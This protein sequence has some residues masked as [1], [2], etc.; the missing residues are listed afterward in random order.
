MPIDIRPPAEDELRASMIAAETA[1][2]VGAIEDVDWERERKALPVSR[3]LAAFDRGKPVALAGAYKFDLTVPGGELPCAGVTWVGVMPTHRRQ[4]ILRDFMKRQLADVQGWGEPIA[5]LWASEAAIYGRFGYGHAIPNAHMK[6][7]SA[8]FAL[9]DAAAGSIRL[10]DAE[11]AF[12]LVRPVYERVRA[13]RTGMLSRDE[14]W[15]KEH[16]LAEHESWRHGASRKFY[17]VVEI[18]GEVEGYALYRVKD[19]WQDGFARGEVRVI[20]ALATSPA[21]ERALW[22]FLHEIDLTVRVEVYY[23]DLGSPLP[24]MVRDPRALGLRLGDGVWLRLV[25]LDAALKA[26]SYR[27]GESLVLEVTDE[28]CPWNAGR[29]RVGDDAGRTEDTA[30]LALDTADLASAYLGAFDFHRL[31]HAGRADER[32]EGA[33]EA[34]TLLFR[35]DLPPYCPEVF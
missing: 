6:S 24:L 1:F 18:D 13:V 28:L 35:T 17:A 34:A 33:A 20:E 23:F 26:R 8:R 16:R 2:G 10:V 31:V 4:G 7:D 22:S 11:E 29:Y 25:D 14:R 21:A 3:A 5:A 12:D 30:D 19:E 9:R 27:P 15:W 32:R